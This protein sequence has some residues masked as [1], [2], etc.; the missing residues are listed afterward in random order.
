M[1]VTVSDIPVVS[2]AACESRAVYSRL[3]ASADTNQLSHTNTPTTLT[4]TQ[5]GYMK[6]LT[7]LYTVN[8]TSAV[9]P[10]YSPMTRGQSN[11]TKSASRGANSPVKGHPRGSKVVPLNSWG[12]VSY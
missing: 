2:L 9:Q 10:H 8:H 3:L 1:L 7:L 4:S 11:L 5:A 6:H 12:R